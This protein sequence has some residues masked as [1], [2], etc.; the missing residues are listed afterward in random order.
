MKCDERLLARR[1]FHVL[2]YFLLVVDQKIPS[3][4]GR[5]F[6]LRHVRS[7]KKWSLG[8]PLSA[9][10][11]CSDVRRPYCEARAKRHRAA[12]SWIYSDFSKSRAMLKH[13]GIGDSQ[14]FANLRVSFREHGSSHVSSVRTA[15]RWYQR[16]AGRAMPSCLMR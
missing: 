10:I 2:E 6:N 13:A 12:R 1:R 14:L 5:D 11:V 7:S 3:F 16:R 8:P 9:G 15:Q 4:V